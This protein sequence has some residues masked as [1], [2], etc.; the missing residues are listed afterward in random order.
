[1]SSLTNV[2]DGIDAFYPHVKVVLPPRGL[3]NDKPVSHIKFLD[4]E[5][6]PFDEH[7]NHSLRPKHTIFLDTGSPVVWKMIRGED[8]DDKLLHNL[9]KL[10]LLPDTEDEED[11]EE[12]KSEYD[13][14]R[15]KERELILKMLQGKY[16]SF[17]ND[18]YNSLRG[19]E[20][21][22]NHL[23]SRLGYYHDDLCL[24]H[25]R[26]GST[27]RDIVCQLT[28][29]YI[30]GPVTEKERSENGKLING[31]SPIGD[32]S[33][34]GEIYIH[35]FH[36]ENIITKVNKDFDEFMLQEA[37]VNMC[38]INSFLET[39]SNAPLVPTYGFFICGRD[40]GSKRTRMCVT[41]TD[42]KVGVD[43]LDGIPHL[44]IVQKA[45]TDVI[46]LHKLIQNPRLSLDTFLRIFVNV[47]HT[48][49]QLQK[50]PYQLTHNDLH[51]N[52]ILVAPDGSKVWIIDWGM[53]SFTLD[54]LDG[55]RYRFIHSNE[56]QYHNFQPYST[57]KKILLSGAY[58]MNLFLIDMM[59]AS[60]PEIVTWCSTMKSV[61]FEE[62]IPLL[63]LFMYNY[64]VNLLNEFTYSTLLKKIREHDP[65]VDIIY[66]E[67]LQNG[68]LGKRKR[69][70]RKNN[71]KKRNYSKS[72]Y[73]QK[74][75]K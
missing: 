46:S 32:E 54:G 48:L 42:K 33:A 38:I 71:K 27:L 68:K 21:L 55:K 58:D 28:L 69:S 35:P 29:A 73:L 31:K 50:V 39:H 13:T 18:N 25:E 20:I 2:S 62:K 19:N 30:P 15:R 7:I 63:E 60:N 4:S 34:N 17:P 45:L 9:D 6:K 3:T 67:L 47:F 56:R 16:P 66:N 40:M 65:R 36:G 12:K 24:K 72:L 8:Q 26:T 23:V 1:M 52:N 49:E 59:S 5:P 44:M 41:S 53:A 57:K 37:V 14:Y 43:G 11:D 51:S 70:R 22:M 74:K 75:N 10:R 61:L 64:D